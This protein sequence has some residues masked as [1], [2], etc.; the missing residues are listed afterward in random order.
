VQLPPDWPF[1]RIHLELLLGQLSLD[2]RHVRRLPCEY[3]SV[4]LQKLD[5]H[6][7]LFV[8]E[9]RADDHSL[10]LNGEPEVDPLCILSRPH[11][12]RARRFVRGDHEAILC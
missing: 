2:S 6:A 11:R 7:F 5:K 10:A 9:A 12:G 1:L 8:G 3:V 4:V